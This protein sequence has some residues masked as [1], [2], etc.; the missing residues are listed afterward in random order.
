MPLIVKRE[1]PPED[2]MGRTQQRV[3]HAYFTVSHLFKVTA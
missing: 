2:S 3:Q 1:M